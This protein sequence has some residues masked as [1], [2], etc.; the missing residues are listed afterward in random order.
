MQWP[1]TYERKVRF[2]D[3]D[4]QGI[5]FNGNYLTYF[6][7]AITDLFIAAGLTPSEMHKDGYDVVTAHASV[8]FRATATLFEDLR[9]GVRL[10]RIGNASLTFELESRAADRVTAE[11]KVIYV[12]VDASSFRPTPVPESLVAAMQAVHPEPIAIERTQ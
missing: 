1:V 2:S 12:T 3:T 7:D 5:V 11:G 8:D 4:S 6:D 9:T 10:T